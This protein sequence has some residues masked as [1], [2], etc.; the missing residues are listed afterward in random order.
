MHELSIA[1]N[2]LE[3]VEESACENK[4]DKVVLLEIE[5]GEMSGVISEALKLALEVSVK[6]TLLEKSEIGIFELAGK[7]RCR[8]CN[9]VYEVHD[10]YSV[11]PFC[12]SYDPDIIEGKEMKIRTIKFESD[13]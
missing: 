13:C 1:E 12:Q 11:C 8:S 10:L 2:I 5:I 7:A 4:A 9:E 3:I 6:G